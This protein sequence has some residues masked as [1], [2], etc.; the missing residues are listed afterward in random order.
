MEGQ[1]NAA[2]GRVVGAGVLHNLGADLFLCFVFAFPSSRK[3]ECSNQLFA[4]IFGVQIDFGAE[5][6]AHYILKLA[7]I[8]GV[9]IFGAQIFV[10]IFGAQIFAQIFR[11]F[12]FDILALQ[13]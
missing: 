7:Q 1:A 12:F 2:R 5:F 9:Q 11:I 6:C 10:Q 8:F 13:K 3:M 4:Q